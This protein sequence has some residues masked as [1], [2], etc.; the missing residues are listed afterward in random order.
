[1]SKAVNN[2]TDIKEYRVIILT[3][4]E[5]LTEGPQYT[6]APSK[7]RVKWYRCKV[8]REQLA[9]LNK[10]SDF[11]GFCQTLGFLLVLGIGAGSAIYSSLYL[12]LYVTILLVFIN[13]HFWHFLVK[14][15][16][17]TIEYGINN[18]SLL[19]R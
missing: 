5:V 8:T 11:L 13:G 6:V 17:T 1:M 2:N 4:A 3:D 12:P 18:I 14:I 19:F 7:N 15:R 9:K 16:N 10:R